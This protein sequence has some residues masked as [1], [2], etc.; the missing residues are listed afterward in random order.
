MM[1]YLN[2]EY[3][4]S[5]AN[6]LITLDDFIPFTLLPTQTF[7]ERSIWL[8]KN[9]KKELIKLNRKYKI[10]FRTTYEIWSARDHLIWVMEHDKEFVEK[11]PEYSDMISNRD[12]FEQELIR[13]K[14]EKLIKEK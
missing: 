8:E 3:I 1:D 12:K 7:Y 14:K 4:Q 9:N 5:I 13:L 6:E 10:S 2:E 11:H